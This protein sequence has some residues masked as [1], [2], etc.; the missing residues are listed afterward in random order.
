MISV[1]T[2]LVFFSLVLVITGQ[3]GSLF[4]FPAEGY[5]WLSATGVIHFVFG[6]SL[7]YYCVQRAGAN[8]ATIITRV[9]P[10]VSVILAI[11]VLGELLTWEIAGGALLI[12]SGVTL[13][14]INPGAIRDRR[15]AFSGLSLSAIISGVGVGFIWGT[16]PIMIK[17][18]LGESGSPIAGAFISYLAGSIAWGFFLLSRNR[19]TEIAG[20]N[21]RA[22]GFFCLAGVFSSAANVARYSALSMA[23]ASVVTP[24]ISI[25]PIFTIIL[26]FFFNR[27]IEVF[28]KTVIIGTLAAVIGTILLV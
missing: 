21:K 6:R 23:P 16:S 1:P 4:T 25:H 22:F 5:L 3:T 20:I 26:S 11:T 10:L 24:I 17:L 2:G 28:R 15:Q 12:V 9:S 19:R 8:I 27:Q 14:G 18:G 13:A 7:Y